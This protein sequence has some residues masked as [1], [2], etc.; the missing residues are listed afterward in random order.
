MIEQLRADLNRNILFSHW[1]FYP[2]FDEDFSIIHTLRQF[3]QNG[4]STFVLCSS[5]SEN[6]FMAR[7]HLSHLEGIRNK[8]SDNEFDGDNV[9][10]NSEELRY[11]KLWGTN[12][13]ER[14]LA[15]IF[16]NDY[17]TFIQNIKPS[18]SRITFNNYVDKNLIIYY[19]KYEPITAFKML[20]NILGGEMNSWCLIHEAP[21]LGW[22][23]I[24]FFERD[25]YLSKIYKPTDSFFIFSRSQSN[26]NM[27]WN[28][29]EE[30]EDEYYVTD[31]YS[32]ELVRGP[33][34][35]V[36]F[37]CRQRGRSERSLEN[38][39]A[40]WSI[41]EGDRLFGLRFNNMILSE[42]RYE[43]LWTESFGE[44]NGMN[45][46]DYE[47]YFRRENMLE[48]YLDIF[49]RRNTREARMPEIHNYPHPFFDDNN[50]PRLE[51]NTYIKYILIG[52]AAHSVNETYV[53]NIN[54]LDN[55][56]Y[57]LSIINAFDI[58]GETKT[59]KLLA[60]A[61][62]GVLLL[63]L[64]P[65]AIQYNTDIRED[66]NVTGVTA[67][68]WQVNN[69]S[70]HHRID[71]IS[72]L[73]CVSGRN[74]LCFIAPPKISNFIANGLIVMPNQLVLPNNIEINNTLNN[75]NQNAN[76]QCVAINGANVPSSVLIQQAFGLQ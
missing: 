15:E 17:S 2:C 68:F 70:I 47:S 49:R 52:E 1:A 56:Q 51:E 29:T 28:V 30:E 50:Y 67:A 44:I 9:E 7:N 19:I 6:Q 16:K 61:R 74:K 41:G 14:E 20:Y 27:P 39:K 75:G 26:Q 37:F 65:F 64:F 53:Y 72:N 54:H 32:G 8:L 45:I 55:T 71:L 18:I 35:R 42:W 43:Q 62:K 69:Y 12:E 48:D 5:F 31:D 57:F 24:K 60:L 25:G 11:N 3:S 63:D 76:F 21:M 4:I 58:E 10:I 23:G 40:A 66:L 22:N 59:E 13:V 33:I 73:F 34:E 46:P 36:F 38:I